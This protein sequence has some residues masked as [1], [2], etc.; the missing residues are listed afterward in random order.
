MNSPAPSESIATLAGGCFWCLEAVYLRLEGV[1]G[2]KSGYMGGHAPDPTYRDVC[3]GDT[4][5]AEVVQVRFDPAVTSFAD[6][7]E[8]FFAIHDPTTPD[9]QGNDVGSQYRSAIFCHDPAQERV[10]RDTVARL[11]REGAFGDPIVTRIEPAA[12]F[13]PAEAFHDDYFARNPN[14]PY[15]RFVVAPK[16]ETF[17]RKFPRRARPA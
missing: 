12:R 13:H 1:L 4:G 15:C 11:D 10:A 6:L 16:V 7:L 3:E 5:H 17:L 14:Q 8:V 9:R 2:V